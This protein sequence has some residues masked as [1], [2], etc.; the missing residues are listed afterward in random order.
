MLKGGSD[1]SVYRWIVGCM[2]L[3]RYFNMGKLVYGL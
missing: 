2:Y 1:M 3:P